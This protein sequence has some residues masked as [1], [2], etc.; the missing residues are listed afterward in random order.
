MPISSPGCYV[1]TSSLINLITPS[2][3]SHQMLIA[4]LDKKNLWDQ[5]YTSTLTQLEVHRVAIHDNNPVLATTA[6]QLLAGIVVLPISDDVLGRAMDIPFHT[7]S[8]DAIHVGTA[9]AAQTILTS[10]KNMVKVLTLLAA[11]SYWATMYN[12]REIIG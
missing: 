10:D 4:H 11:D 8:L 2:N 12:F 5:L 3:P 7:K 9:A 1:D 6:D